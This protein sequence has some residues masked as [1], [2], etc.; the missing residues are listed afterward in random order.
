MDW[1]QLTYALILNGL[2]HDT[3]LMQVKVQCTIL[4]MMI[5]LGTIAWLFRSAKININNVFKSKHQLSKNCNAKESIA[6]FSIPS[7]PRLCKPIS[8][9]SIWHLNSEYACDCKCD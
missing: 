1:F 9:N 4:P 3:A 7:K 6:N 8:L 2:E 5:Y